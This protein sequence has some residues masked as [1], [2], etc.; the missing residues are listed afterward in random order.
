[1]AVGS[2]GR[3]KI[4]GVLGFLLLGGILAGCLQKDLAPL[5][6][7][8]V[9]GV[10]QE[11]RVENVDKVDL[12]MVVDN[13]MSMAQEQ[14]KLRD[15]LPRL[16]QVLA[17]GD[18]EAGQMAGTEG[19]G[20]QDFP[21]VKDLRIGVLT[22]DLGVGGQS[23]PDCTA[24]GD[25]GKLI[26]TTGEPAPVGCGAN[27]YGMG[28]KFVSYEPET[29]TDSP[30]QFAD[31]VACVALT[32]AGGCGFEQQLE[33]PLKAVTP[34]TSSLTFQGGVK[35]NGEANGFV[36]SDSLLVLMLITDEEDCSALNGE[37][38]NANSQVFVAPATAINVRCARF[39]QALHPIDRYVN[40]FMDLRKDNPGLLVFAAV[41]G[42]PTDLDDASL[43]VILA[44]PDMAPDGKYPE[45][46]D[47][48]K[49]PILK[50]S[51]SAGSDGTADPP[52]RIVQVAKGL[53]DSGAAVTVKSICA[54]DFGPALDEVIR[55]IADAL[56]GA[57]L[58]RPLN[59]DAGNKVNCDVV[60]VLPEGQKC[61]DL[62]NLGRTFL[63]VETDKDTGTDREVCRITQLPATETGAAAPDGAGWYYEFDNSD[64]VATP[65][66]DL[67][68]RCGA[69]KQRVAFKS[70]SKPQNGADL[71]LECLQSVQAGDETTL[72]VGGFPCDANAT[73][74]P[75]KQV[76][77]QDCP[78]DYKLICDPLTLSW[79][80]PCT[81]DSDCEPFT[82]DNV[83][84]SRGTKDGPPAICVN[85]TCD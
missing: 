6:P 72:D 36:R 75:G 4:K 11:V 41:T 54:P 33:S 21:P 9:S 74:E 22:T 7:C 19:L 2:Q 16:V 62:K 38:F 3:S 23:V 59:P 85:P 58:P 43:D 57:C 82:C 49:R 25:D 32:G 15:Q 47:V 18:K 81:N 27:G 61:D 30:E 12:L 65:P 8:T 52:R 14:A 26:T 45:T 78:A 83:T 76:N 79:Q 68:K 66:T 13:S 46:Q 20:V 28:Q 64:V 73:C 34:S 29:S 60:E 39:P 71:R 69:H 37:V 31:K 40:G 50:P 42:I 70:D 53:E 35:G 1:M 84:Q 67:Q 24:K 63:R 48:N 10:V 77:G 56:G 80:I 17:S 55:K 5:I 44:D 51:C